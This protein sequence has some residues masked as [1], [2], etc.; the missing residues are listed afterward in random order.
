MARAST[1]RLRAT[2][3]GVTSGGADAVGSNVSATHPL[4]LLTRI[5]TGPN[6]RSA[7]SKTAPAAPSSSRSRSI[8]A[9]RPGSASV[10][11]STSPPSWL[12]AT[13]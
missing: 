6:R 2:A 5:D 10:A 3:S 9:T 11:A 7:S 12:R 8:A 13:A 4:A 1:P